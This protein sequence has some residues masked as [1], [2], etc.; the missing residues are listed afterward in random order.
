[1]M[2]I[3][4]FSILGFVLAGIVLAYGVLS[5]STSAAT[6]LNEHALMIVLG[7]SI[8]S[9]SIAFR[10]DKILKLF[11]IFFLRVLKGN[12]VEFISLIEELMRL[13]DANRL[14]PLE[15]QKA[16][17]LIKD[18]FLKDAIL[19]SQDGI[20]DRHRLEK[21]LRTRVQTIYQRYVEDA[22][23]FKTVGKYPPA[24]GLMG[25]TLGMIA[26]L[27]KLGDPN[28]Q[29]L[30]GPSMAVAL[31]ATF[32]GLSLSNLVFGPVAEN[33]MDSAREN[34]IKNNIIVEG[35]LLI[36]DK[37]NPLIL[38][39][40][41]NSYLLPSERIQTKKPVSKPQNRGNIGKAA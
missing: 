25:T 37:T 7:G 8:A 28:G 3:N 11:K 16:V 33:L 30:I 4:P 13:A 23:K 26:L 2:H 10:L 1:M 41:L 35:V 5:S 24:F 31:I 32:L 9:A 14:S 21:V 6:F 34:K 40:E 17:E 36:L 12:K 38:A 15:F 20:M 27:Q 39:D 29:K 22:I 18:P 19:L